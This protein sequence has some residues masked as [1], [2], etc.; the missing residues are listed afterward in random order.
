[1]NRIFETNGSKGMS[2]QEVETECAFNFQHTR[3][4]GQCVTVWRLL[5]PRCLDGVRPLAQRP[6]QRVHGVAQGRRDV[7][8]Q[9]D[10]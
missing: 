9:V 6:E 1:M 3:G 5:A 8:V 10:I 7:G 2:F 4:G